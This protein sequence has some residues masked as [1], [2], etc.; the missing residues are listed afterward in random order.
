[1]FFGGQWANVY[2]AVLIFLVSCLS[3]IPVKYCKN[4]APAFIFVGASI[5]GAY[6]LSL[7]YALLPE[8]M[9]YEFK[10]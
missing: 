5:I 8:G 2:S 3:S 1:M 7:Y 4:I 6:D 10:T 9:N